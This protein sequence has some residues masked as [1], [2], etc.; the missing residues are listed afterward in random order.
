MGRAKV[1]L[2]ITGCILVGGIAWWRV[3][4]FHDANQ[5]KPARPG[6]S[7]TESKNP[8]QKGVPPEQ[9]REGLGAGGI[10]GGPQGSGNQGTEARPG[11]RPAATDHLPA[12]IG[13]ATMTA[14]GTIVLDLRAEGPGGMIGDSRLV[15][16][17]TDKQYAEILKH[18]GGLRPGEHKS[19]PPW[20]DSPQ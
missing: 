1:W 2:I 10:S 9:G 4:R 14:D 8:G 20:P 5:S 18:L 13:T 12:S 11:T 15:Y 7:E 19:V 17:R 3:Q 16:P 6:L